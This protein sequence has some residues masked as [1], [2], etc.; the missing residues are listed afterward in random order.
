[1]R[2]FCRNGSW[3]ELCYKTLLEEGFKAKVAMERGVCTKAVEHIIEANTFLSGLGFESGGLGT[4]HAIHNGL[5]VLKECHDRYHGEK[6]GF[7]GADP[8]DS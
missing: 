4:R 3:S 2:G 7:W 8:A 6:S 1:M 5:T